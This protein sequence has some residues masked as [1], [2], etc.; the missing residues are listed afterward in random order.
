MF[1]RQLPSSAGAASGTGTIGT[2]LLEDVM[3][4]HRRCGAHLVAA[5]GNVPIAGVVASIA[6]VNRLLFT[7][8]ISSPVLLFGVLFVDRLAAV[9]RTARKPACPAVRRSVARKIWQKYGPKWACAGRN[10]LVK[11][12]CTAGIR[13]RA[14]FV[15]ARSKGPLREPAATS[16]PATGSPA[17]RDECV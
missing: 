8:C 13:T 5:T 1:R 6:A 15:I 12:F 10:G 17:P 4:F 14:D 16:A 2:F 7:A 9:C 11:K 3:G